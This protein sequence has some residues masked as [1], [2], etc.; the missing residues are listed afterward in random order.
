MYKVFRLRLSKL[1][2]KLAYDTIHR[3]CCFFF[4]AVLFPL[5]S[6]AAIL[7]LAYVMTHKIKHLQC[8]EAE[9]Y[10]HDVSVVCLQRR[11]FTRFFCIHTMFCFFLLV[12]LSSQTGIQLEV[13]RR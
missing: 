6:I 13:E 9:I 10:D 4:F 8:S 5:L 1:A 7:A 2:V 11:K 12:F 3:C